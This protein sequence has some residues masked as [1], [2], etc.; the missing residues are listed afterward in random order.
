M[1]T[2]RSAAPGRARGPPGRAAVKGVNAPVAPVHRVLTGRLT[3]G[4][5]ISTT[6]CLLYVLDGSPSG[7]PP[8]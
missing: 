8:S 6:S 4:Y 1:L 3:C 2:N 7:R 5:P